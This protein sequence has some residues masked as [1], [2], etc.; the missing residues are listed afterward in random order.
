MEVRLRLALP[1][2]VALGGCKVVDAPADL[3]D[4][5]VY[6]FD[7]YDR[8]PDFLAAM[9]QNLFPQVDDQ[10]DV[11]A[12][13]YRISSLTADDVAAAGVED[14]TVTTILGAMG[15]VDYRHPI[16]DIVPPMIAPNRAELFDQIQSYDVTSEDGDRDAFIA[17]DTDRYD[18][19]ATQTVSVTL[20]GDSTQ[21]FDANYR[22][23]TPDEGDPFVVI[24]TLSPGGVA[25]NSNIMVVHQQYGLAVLYPHGDTARR[26]EAFWVDAEVIGMDVPDYYAV[27]Q[28]AKTMADQAQRVDDYVDGVTGVSTVPE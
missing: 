2:L 18:F 7:N 11:I 15:S 5:M 19:S 27:E 9:G 28:A 25:F 26:V 3:E 21:S 8:D 12:N 6:G 13:G 1:L 4:L 20:L 10:F 17:G 14:A 24:R 22:R 23:I 16:A